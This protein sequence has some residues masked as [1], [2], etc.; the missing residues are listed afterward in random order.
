M[1]QEMSPLAVKVFCCI[2]L[3]SENANPKVASLLDAARG[4]A[5]RYHIYIA[6]FS[7]F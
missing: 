1:L 3:Y 6:L 7:V 5:V 2:I 4:L